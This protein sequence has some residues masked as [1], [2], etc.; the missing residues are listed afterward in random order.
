MGVG[1][2]AVQKRRVS[3][4]VGDFYCEEKPTRYFRPGEDLL[5]GIFN[6]D[7]SKSGH[8]RCRRWNAYLWSRILND[9]ISR[10]SVCSIRFGRQVPKRS[11]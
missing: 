3:V 7:L 5:N 6:G 9:I 11:G 4:F 10:L 1:S 8:Q 2:Y